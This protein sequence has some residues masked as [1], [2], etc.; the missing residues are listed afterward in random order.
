MYG[1][2]AAGPRWHIQLLGLA[3][4]LFKTQVTRSGVEHQ[5]RREIE[6][7]S[8]LRYVPSPPSAALAW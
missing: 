2:R 1:V 3:Q 7:Q 6:I 4:I 5:L 8:N